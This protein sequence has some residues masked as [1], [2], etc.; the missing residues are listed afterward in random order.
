M[1]LTLMV[2]TLKMLRTDIWAEVGT[3]QLTLSV[4]LFHIQWDNIFHIDME[5]STGAIADYCFER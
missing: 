2:L 5:R 1:M 3:N 4:V